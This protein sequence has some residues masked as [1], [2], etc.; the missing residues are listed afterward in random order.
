M[1]ATTAKA[2]LQH[3]LPIVSETKEETLAEKWMWS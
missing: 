1:L 2:E 3:H